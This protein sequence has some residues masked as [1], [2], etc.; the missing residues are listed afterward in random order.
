MSSTEQDETEPLW[1]P[2]PERVE[3]ANITRFQSWAAQRHG[4]PTATEGDPLA[5]Y[6]AL[7]AW[8]VREPDQFW[9]AVAEWFDVRF[10]SP[11]Q[12]VLADAAMPGARW[13]PGATLNYAEHA[14]RRATEHPAETAL[15][16]LDERRQPQ[17]TSWAEL[18]RQVAAVA[19]LLRDLGVRPGDRVSGYLPNI[20]HAV[21]ALL[22]T[23]AVGGVWTSCA[24]DFGARSVLDRFQQVEPVVLFTVDGY[25][26]GGKTHDRTD[27]V[28][29][30]RR[31]LPTLRAVVHVPL[32]GTPTPD[33]AVDWDQAI[34]GD[35][36]LHVEQVPFDHPLWVLYSSGTTGLPKAIVQSQGGILLEHLKQ[37]A[38]HF[39]LGPDDRFFWYTSTGWMMWNFLVGGLLAGATVVLYDG[40]PGYPERDAQWRIAEQTGVT[41]FGTSAAYVV[42]CRKADLHPGRDLDLRRVRCVATTG[43]PLPPDGFSWVYQEVGSDI[44]LASVSGGTDVCSCFAGGVP[45]LPVYLGE[46]QAP[47]LGSDVQSWDATGA[48]VVDEVGELVVTGPMPSMPVRFWNDPDDQRYR[49]SYF[50]T[51]PGVWRHGDWIT[52]TSRGT[53]IVHGRSDSTLNRAGVR[54]G[55]ADIYEAVERLPQVRESLVIGVEQPDGGYWMPLFVHLA[56]GSRLDDA[57]RDEIKRTI[58]DQVSPRHVPDEIIEVPG[59][60]HTLTG[61]RIEVPVK[62]LLQGAALDKAV[63]P[64]SVDDVTLLE[65]FA[66]LA[67]ERAATNPDR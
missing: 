27:T 30:L 44:W 54:M 43:S 13:F 39:D 9:Q 28:A 25:T 10:T 51:Y 14:L 46:L 49:E 26:Y 65:F 2:R 11:H 61:K 52:L 38:L 22:A 58:R 37:T 57:L 63:N 31:E 23:A 55:S 64:G 6:R 21:V 42:A 59:V 17:Q 66:R 19:A 48:P 41:V 5:S 12:S 20:P 53:V 60:P 50:A 45:T 40:S 4:A 34:S 33:G 1:Q 56:D 47:C 36:E 62:K 35:H 24:P 8:S 18:R 3:A 7:H 29:E 16:H 67:R 32:L 15:I